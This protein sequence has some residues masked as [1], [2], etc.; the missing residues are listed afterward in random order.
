MTSVNT[1]IFQLS[2]YVL[3]ARAA[4]PNRLQEALFWYRGEVLTAIAAKDLAALPAMV[5]SASEPEF[6]LTALTTRYCMIRHPEGRKCRVFL[7]YCLP[8]AI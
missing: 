7:I 6:Y 3:K 8:R 1:F 2:A 5:L 4:K